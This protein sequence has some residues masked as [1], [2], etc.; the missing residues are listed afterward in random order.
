MSP[1]P[2]AVAT[3]MLKGGTTKSTITANVAEA[4]SRAG[5]DV[6]AVDTDPNGH[7]TVNL[8]Y[9]ERYHDSDV[10]LGDVILA[11]GTAEPQEAIVDT[12]LGFD[13]LPATET[14]ETTEKQLQ[15]EG[16]PSLCMKYELVDPL[17]GE[18]YDY[19]LI[20]THSSRNMLVSNATV[21]APNVLIPLIPEQG[22]YSGLRRTRERV[23]KPL[24]DRIGLDVL[25]LVPNKLS[26]RIDY[27]TDDRQLIERICTADAL[28]ERVP[29]FA[30]VEPETL[31]ALDS[32]DA[33]ASQLPKPGIRQDTAINTAF[34]NNQTLGAYDP[35]NEQL[36]CFDEL[37]EIVMHGEVTRDG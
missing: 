26:Q 22:I 36:A 19:I 11:D 2:R 3:T 29:N 14:L 35:D 17:L 32:P 9:D 5:Q 37:A 23:V 10:D 33:S 4:L 24:R 18:Q 34:S 13:L 31:Q 1:E 16:Q 15:S 6:L 7:M 12:G 25:A 28:A 8:G 20:D 30:W 21:A 27:Q